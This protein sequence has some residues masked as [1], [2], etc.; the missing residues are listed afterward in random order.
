MFIR[1]YRT[2]GP[3]DNPVKRGSFELIGFVVFDDRE[4]LGVDRLLIELK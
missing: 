4:T 2:G 1:F 3:L